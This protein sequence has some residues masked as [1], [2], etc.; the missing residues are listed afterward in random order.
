MRTRGPTTSSLGSSLPRCSTSGTSPTSRTSPRR[1]GKTRRPTPGACVRSRSGPPGLAAI[2][3]AGYDLVWVSSGWSHLD[4]RTVD[5]RIESPGVSEFELVVIRQT[6]VGK[7]LQ[8]IDPYGLAEMTRTRIE[9]AFR[10]AAAIPASLTTDLNS[11][12][13][14]CRHRIRRSSTPRRVQKPMAVPTRDGTCPLP[15]KWRPA[16]GRPE[17]REM[18]K[19]SGR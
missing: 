19:Q 14:M 11:S 1:T 6:A 5:R 3:A 18:C 16:S 12:L 13:F 7:L 4:I 15:V 10:S 17:K 9:A 8:S 2:R